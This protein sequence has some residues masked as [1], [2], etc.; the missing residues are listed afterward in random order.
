MNIELD[1]AIAYFLGW[2]IDNSFPD[3]GKVWRKGNAIELETTFKFSEDWNI[4]MEAVTAIENIGFNFHTHQ[5][6]VLIDRNDIGLSKD[7]DDPEI[8][9]RSSRVDFDKKLA[10]YTAV[11]KFAIWYNGLQLKKNA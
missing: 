4:L 5:A 1:K 10:T 7:I 2:R 3:K 8:E 9:V 6:R 11:S